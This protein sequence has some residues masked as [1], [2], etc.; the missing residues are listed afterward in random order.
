MHIGRGGRSVDQVRLACSA[1][2]AVG[3]LLQGGRHSSR[4]AGQPQGTTADAHPSA[5][6]AA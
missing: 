2:L 1:G 6:P 5:R 4:H 3:S